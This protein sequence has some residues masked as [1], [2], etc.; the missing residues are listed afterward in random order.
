MSSHKP[1]SQR[2]GGLPRWN[3]AETEDRPADGGVGGGG[4]Q[5]QDQSRGPG[6]LLGSW[7]PLGMT[8]GSGDRP[9]DPS[10]HWG[11]LASALL[12]S[13]P[14]RAGPQPTL[15][16][17]RDS[18]AS[19]PLPWPLALSWTQIW[20]QVL[21]EG[22]DAGLQA[23]AVLPGQGL[24]PHRASRSPAL[25]PGEC[26]TWEDPYV[27]LIPTA[28]RLWSHFPASPACSEGGGEKS[29]WSPRAA[30][31]LQGDWI[32]GR[33]WVRE[34][35]PCGLPL[36]WGLQAVLPLLGSVMAL[37][38]VGRGQGLACPPRWQSR[39]G[40]P[41]EPRR[42]RG[43]R[44]FRGEGPHGHLPSP[45]VTSRRAGEAGQSGQVTQRALG[46]TAGAGR[47]PRGC[48]ADEPR[49]WPRGQGR[50]C[51]LVRCGLWEAPTIPGGT[52]QEPT[53]A[54]SS[55]CP[56]GRAGPPGGA[57]HWVS[58]GGSSGMR[59]PGGVPSSLL[60]AS[61]R[62]AVSLRSGAPLQ[63]DPPHPEL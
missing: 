21:C 52:S 39:E 5:Q 7:L 63:A 56:G 47:P 34:R 17:T 11:W 59:C 31:G 28:Q 12:D 9:G 37:T 20:G 45:E 41:P 54:V 18:A 62:G 32:S 3:I 61:P 22:H 57:E 6:R 43:A 58:P 51:G 42:Q 4:R 50:G 23:K 14:G 48:A 35:V 26:G 40:L 30:G 49:D 13:H 27:P 19:C 44:C 33:S 53:V 8:P 16:P 2:R 1:G 46:I 10:G 24:D 55:V 60:A 15:P 36:G 29:R 25:V 38:S